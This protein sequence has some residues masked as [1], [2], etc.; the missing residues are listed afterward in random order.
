MKLKSKPIKLFM[1]LLSL[2]SLFVL[3]YFTF[4]N[5]GHNLCPRLVPSYILLIYLILS[6][7]IIVPL[8]YLFISKKL[9]SKFNENLKVLSKIVNKKESSEKINDKNNNLDAKGIVL[10]LLSQNEKNIFNLLIE[11]KGVI[12]QSKINY[13]EGMNK[14]K[15]H[16]A[17]KELVKKDIVYVKNHGKTNKI[18]LTKSI[19]E[20]VIVKS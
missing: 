12:L 20:L 2:V 8:T 1:F 5:D 15:T 11:N 3:L 10:K 9:E 14:L 6:I 19:K 13:L 7:L 17:I 18:Y 16:R 4:F